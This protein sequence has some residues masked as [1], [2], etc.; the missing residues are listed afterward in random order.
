MLEGKPLVR[1]DWPSFQ[2][3]CSNGLISSPNIIK[4]PGHPKTWAPLIR[5]ALPSREQ[6]IFQDRP[7]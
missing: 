3:Q 4:W 2:N 7:R 5:V 6:H 1:L